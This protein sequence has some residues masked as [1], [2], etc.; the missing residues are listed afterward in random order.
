MKPVALGD[1]DWT[2]QSSVA[3]GFFDGVHLGHQCLMQETI[4]LA[5]DTLL[6]VVFTFRNHPAT[7]VSSKAPP[8]LTTFEERCE[9]LSELGLQVVWANFDAAFSQQTPIQ[10]IQEVLVKTLKANWVI[11]GDNYRFGH[12]A[13]GNPKLLQMCSQF[14]SVVVPDVAHQG[15][16]ISSSRIRQS[17]QDGQVEEAQKLLGRPYS[18]Q[19]DVISGRKLG[20]ELGVPTAN[21]QVNP[22]KVCPRFGVYAVTATC[23]GIRYNGVA[24]LGVRPTVESGQAE[25]L[26]ETNL[27]DFNQNLY[28]KSVK[29]EF[30]HWLRTEEK[31]ADLESLKVQMQND[32]ASARRLLSQ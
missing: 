6:P 25:T 3:L 2:N 22:E 21:Q 23:E 1:V 24:S 5:G 15:A 30:R 20:R 14:R 12:K 19:A 13:A 28:G 32:I 7:V 31:F 27:F 26:L 17:L 8:L 9:L 11:T 10:F 18:L 4:K 29:I 16:I